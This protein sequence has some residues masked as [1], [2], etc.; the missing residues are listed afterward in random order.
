MVVI[1]FICYFS[2][3]KAELRS[4]GSPAIFSASTF[5]AAS[6]GSPT[7][8]NLPPLTSIL[9]LL[10]RVHPVAREWNSNWLLEQS[11]SKVYPFEIGAHP[12]VEYE[13]LVYG[14]LY[15]FKLLVPL[16]TTANLTTVIWFLVKVPVLSEQ[17]TVVHPRVS[18][19]GSLLTIALF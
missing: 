6:V 2:K 17:I 16:W 11:W 12:I 1:L 7:L 9:E 18:T 5:N 3:L 10:F 8:S 14:T 4:S 15:Y 13:L 19:D